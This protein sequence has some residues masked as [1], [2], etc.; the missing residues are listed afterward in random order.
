[1]PDPY[2]YGPKSIAQR[3]TLHPDLQKL[4]DEIAK[5]VNCSIL[6]GHRNKEDQDAAYSKG[7]SKVTWPNSRHNS[8][9]SEA[10]DIVPFPCNW[11]DIKAFKEMAVKIKEVAE[12]IGVEVEWGGE[13]F[14]PKFRD[15]QH[16]QLVKK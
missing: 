9:P 12:S 5:E 11:Q 13:C 8:T 10:V 1:M 16:W 15:Y 7:T 3:A 14:G 2:K 6:C 4:V